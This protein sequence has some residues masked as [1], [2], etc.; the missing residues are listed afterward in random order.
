[1]GDGCHA[2][3]KADGET[4]R[5]NKFD[6]FFLMLVSTWL[7]LSAGPGVEPSVAVLLLTAGAGTT[8]ERSLVISI[9]GGLS[10]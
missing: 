4:G 9:S 3:N 10:G 1:M 2:A 5:L 7:E 6:E 8:E